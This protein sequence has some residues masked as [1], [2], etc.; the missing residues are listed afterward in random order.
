M[1]RAAVTPERLREAGGKAGER[2]LLFKGKELKTDL[3][4]G[5][6]K[7]EYLGREEDGAPLLGRE[8]VGWCT[9]SP[10]PEAY[11]FSHPPGF[12]A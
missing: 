10:T 12:V 4:E 6:V 5:L 7:C 8:N 3:P 1:V 11:V 9:C 2:V